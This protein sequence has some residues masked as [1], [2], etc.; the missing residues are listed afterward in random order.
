MNLIVFVGKIKEIPVLKESTH[1]NTYATMKIE[2]TRPF[3]NSEGVYETDEFS[4]T[5][6]KGIAQTT[7]Q[8]AGEGDVVAIKGRMQSRPYETK[9]GTTY[10]SYDIIAEKV[11]F[12]G[13]EG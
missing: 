10:L 2:V 5:L 4:V 3:A 12:I 13:K 1:G 11:S 7:V 6:W 8:V 9:D